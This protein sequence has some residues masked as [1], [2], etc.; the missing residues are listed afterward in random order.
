MNPNQTDI[1]FLKIHNKYMYCQ[2][3]SQNKNANGVNLAQAN[4]AKH[5]KAVQMSGRCYRFI[6]RPKTDHSE[7]RGSRIKFLQIS[8]INLNITLTEHKQLQYIL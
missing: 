5:K 8:K 4:T 2:S 1:K 7:E 3:I 6:T